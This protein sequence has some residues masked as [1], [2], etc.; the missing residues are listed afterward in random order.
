MNIV[1]QYQAFLSESIEDQDTFNDIGYLIENIENIDE[2]AMKALSNFGRKAGG[3]VASAASLVGHSAPLSMAIAGS[4]HAA[5]ALHAHGAG[6][7][8]SE[9]LAAHDYIVKMHAGIVGGAATLAAK[10][11]WQEKKRDIK[12]EN[13]SSN[14][15]K[16]AGAVSGRRIKARMDAKRANSKM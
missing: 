16:E 14:M 3:A 7:Y 1:E 4:L 11:G 12:D 9:H 8:T 15:N 10:D 13:R 6:G 2:G 5:V